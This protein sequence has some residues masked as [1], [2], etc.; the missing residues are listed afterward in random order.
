MLRC[1]GFPFAC[2]LGIQVG[3]TAPISSTFEHFV[4]C[5]I[6]MYTHSKGIYTNSYAKY[7]NKRAHQG[8]NPDQLLTGP[9]NARQPTAILFHL[10][11]VARPAL[12]LNP[13]LFNSR[14]ICI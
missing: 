6:E 14:P 9:S 2:R 10:G 1:T 12:T 13:G 3:Y 11:T 4:V 7:S 5:N 8:I